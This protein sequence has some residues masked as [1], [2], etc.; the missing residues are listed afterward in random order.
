MTTTY[1]KFSKES[2]GHSAV[3]LPQSVTSRAHNA[4]VHS[5]ERNRQP[6]RPA[7]CWYPPAMVYVAIAGPRCPL[8]PRGRPM[9]RPRKKAPPSRL[10]PVVGRIARP[11]S[12][13]AQVEQLLRQL[14]ADGR[15]PDG[16]L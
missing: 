16:R 14:I 13:V 5:G 1:Y 7:A 9:P 11:L 10:G 2:Q 12:L 3:A 8:P 4:T 15:F 6:P